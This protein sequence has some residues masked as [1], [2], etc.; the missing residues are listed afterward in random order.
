M[1][2][3]E[4]LRGAYS[5]AHKLDVTLLP[6]WGQLHVSQIF[7]PTI[8]ADEEG[9]RS[10]TQLQS[11][12]Q[13]FCKD[14]DELQLQSY[15]E[16]F[17]D[18]DDE[19]QKRVVLLGEAGTGKTTFLKHFTDVWCGST[20]S[21]QFPDY[22][23]LK[24]F[25]YLFYVSC[26]FASEEETILDMIR[27]QLFGD[28]DKM[29][30]ARY[31]LQHHPGLCLVLVDGL[32]EWV[33]SPST[34]TGRMGDIVGLPGLEGVEKCA[35]VMTSRPWR[36][37]SMPSPVMSVF[38]RLRIHGIQNVF[39]L[40]EQILQ[41]LQDPQPKESAEEF[42]DQVYD[43]NMFD[44]MH[45]PLILIISLG[46][47][48][49]DR[50]L[51]KS[52]CINYIN[53]IQSLICR[54]EGRDDWSKG[55]LQ[56]S[57]PNLDQLKTEWR[58]E[59]KD[60]PQ[61]LLRYKSLHGYASLF[62]SLGHLAFDLLLG[63]EEQ[64][65][66]FSKIFY[67]SYLRTYDEKDE[68]INVCLALGILSKTETTFHGLKKLESY[69][70]CHKTFQEFFAALWLASKYEIEKNKLYQCIKTSKDLLGFEILIQ[71]LCGFDPAI[72]K[73]MWLDVYAEMKVELR[74]QV[75]V[76]ELACRCMKELEVDPKDQKSSQVY[77]CIPHIWIKY[78][79]SD[80]D[81][82]LLCH[83]ME[84]YYSNVKSVHVSDRKSQQ[85]VQ[86]ICK[87][88]SYCSGLRVLWL[89]RLPAVS[90]VLD[91]QKH[92][93]LERL[94]LRNIS[95]EDLLL[96]EEGDTVTT[97]WLDNV[98]M[99]HHGL[100]QLE[101]L[102]SY[103][104]LMKLYVYR[105]S[106]SDNDSVCIPVPD[107]QKHNKLEKLDLMDIS[108][109]GLLLPGEGATITSLELR[110]V[111]MTHHGLKQ[112]LESLSSC[113]SLLNVDLRRVRFSAHAYGTC[114]PVI[115]LQKHNKLEKLDLI[116]ISVEG[117]LLPVEGATITTLELDNVTMTH[118][119]LEQ[120]TESL[121][122]CTSLLKVHLRTVT[123]SEHAGGTCI[124]VIDLRQHNKLDT[125]VLRNMSVEGL[126]LPGEGATITHLW[127]DNVT[128]TH[129]GLKQ[130]AESLSSCNSLLNVDLRRVIC[131]EHAGG[132]CIP[133][134]D[135]RQHNKLDTLEL[136]DISVGGILLPVEGATITTLWL[137]SVTMTRHGL[138]QLAESLSS[139][140]SL[141]YVDLRRVICSEHAGDTCIP[142]IDLR[143]HNK[144]KTL[145][146]EDISVE[147]LLLPE[148]GTT[149]TSLELRDVTMTRHGLKQLAESLSSCISLLYVDLRRVRCS[150]HAGDTCI[151]VID[152]RQHNKL[153][154]L[155]LEDISVGGILLPVEGATITTLW[156]DSV[157]MTRHGLKQLAESLS[158][159]I[160]LLYVDLRRVRCSEHA[161]DTCIPVI[162][163][164]Q[165][166]KLETLE[167]D[168]MLVEGLLMPVKGATIT[169]LVLKD[170]TMTLHGLEQLAESLS[171]CIRLL[172]VDLWTVTCSEHAGGI[173]IPAIDLRQHKKL[174]TLA[175][176]NVSVEGLLLPEEGAT[177]TYLWLDNVTMTHHGLE[178]LEK[179]SSYTNLYILYVDSV[180]CSD[181][182]SVCIPVLDLQQ[183]N[184]LKRLKLRNISVESLLLPV[185]GAT[186]TTLELGNVIM[187]HHGLEQ[188]LDYLSR[189]TRPRSMG[190]YI[191]C[192]EHGCDSSCQPLNDIYKR[193]G[194]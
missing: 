150:E 155:E 159:C 117:L 86:N 136:E 68:S 98:T 126:L 17:Y 32:D 12:K 65:L 78:N 184:K 83:V 71:F 156:L 11:L 157:T 148:E 161:G 91:L 92:N 80:E 39:E 101:K 95:V 123:C 49:N 30:V 4:Y 89:Q 64:S 28:D 173:C 106:C 46:G 144:L 128:M 111:T 193:F 163:L 66:V 61:L 147:G 81:I 53:M 145:E 56:L 116:D 129:H 54:T 134:I 100:K 175:L 102:S 166:N 9:L 26:R 185:G 5:K 190:L 143:Q 167:M 41:Q 25:D 20:S 57:V 192:S 16:M 133:V 154:T 180:S 31:V 113:T 63:K 90:S 59:S 21:L 179:L 158:S 165:H 110:D 172:K 96:P 84:E 107:L 93:K 174:E 194:R 15:K 191:R 10:N 48:V 97:L 8:L 171:F 122:S 74:E 77:F 182:D 189:L 178:Q 131:S 75:K 19:L 45:I 105:V 47:W 73:Q 112:L 104:N 135:L 127:L 67:R 168:D 2:L 188:L 44:L 118:H 3:Q 69:A 162:D 18:D 103:T 58:H 99:T 79:T 121:S 109:E 35:I 27:K 132:T 94:D 72:G 164:R 76:Q 70:F 124:P 139:C 60:F 142:V 50:S 141:L 14:D 169:T 87:S 1:Q 7:A 62:L 183:H 120:L 138:K 187:T 88:I 55:K 24:Q 43:K 115:D 125:L 177:I 40:A 176:R 151:P 37:R 22:D 186:I 85:Q 160:S 130:L 153:D 114:I 146:L 51:H 29:A 108:V 34:D 52:L 6:E 36:F 82:E 137:D 13:M 152:L 38:K 140:I 23:F 33:A 170:V 119:G 181:N 42:L 149:I